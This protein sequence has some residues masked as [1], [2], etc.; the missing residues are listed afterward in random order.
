MTF[1]CDVLSFKV[2]WAGI[3]FHRRGPGRSCSQRSG[4]CLHPHRS[5]LTLSSKYC[6][7]YICWFSCTELSTTDKDR[8]PYSAQGP[9]KFSLRM[10]IVFFSLYMP[11]KAIYW[12]SMLEDIMLCFDRRH[13]KWM[14][15][16]NSTTI[17]LSSII[18]V[19]L[20]KQLNTDK[21]QYQ[22]MYFKVVK[23]MAS[24]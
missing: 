11:G 15:N 12:F 8:C 22:T 3:S 7:N 19:I 20:S 23:T 24:L 17:T 5:T 13:W 21:I 18:S 10:I 1:L 4:D 9:A 14:T 2:I 6:M 16:S